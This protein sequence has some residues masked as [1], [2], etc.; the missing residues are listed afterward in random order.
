MPCITSKANRS[1]NHERSS[2][3]PSSAYPNK[4]DKSN[5]SFQT[6]FI[7]SDFIEETFNCLSHECAMP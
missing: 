5:K 1:G 7:C 3:Y 2:D 6:I 4:V